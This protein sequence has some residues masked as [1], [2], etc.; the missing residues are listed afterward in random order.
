MGRCNALLL[1]AMHT[2]QLAMKCVACH[3]LMVLCTYAFSSRAL[4][5]TQVAEWHAK[6]LIALRQIFDA[7]KA[8][9]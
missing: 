6:Y 4:A 9:T 3:A 8:R 1:Y 2:M 7:S 5:S